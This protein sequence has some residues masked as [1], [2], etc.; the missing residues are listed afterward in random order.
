MGEREKRG[1]EFLLNIDIEMKPEIW[2]SN[3][4]MIQIPYLQNLLYPEIYF[5]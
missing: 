3:Y 4:S 2:F 5:Y 1:S